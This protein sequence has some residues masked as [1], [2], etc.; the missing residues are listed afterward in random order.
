MDDG[1]PIATARFYQKSKDCVIVGR[2]VV[3]P[4]YRGQNL[5]DKVLQEAESWIR[6]LGYREIE[7]DSRTVAVGFYEKNGFC[8]ISE[9]IVKSGSFD[10]IRMNKVLT[11]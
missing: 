11:C 8:R 4:E 7:V 2:V 5:G 6:E 9:D 3:L 10:C 1:Y